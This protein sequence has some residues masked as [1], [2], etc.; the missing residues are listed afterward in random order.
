MIRVPVQFIQG[1]SVETSAH[2]LRRLPQG[3]WGVLVDG[4][5]F[6]IDAAGMVNLDGQ[7]F[8]PRDCPPALDL[9][10]EFL[11]MA[12]RTAILNCRMEASPAGY[13]ILHLDGS[14]DQ[15]SETVAALEARGSQIDCFGTAYR[16][17]DNG[18]QYQWFIRLKDS[19][20]DPWKV[21]SC[22]GH[23]ESGGPNIV[24]DPRIAELGA[25]LAR[26]GDALANAEAA[27]SEQETRHQQSLEAISVQAAMLRAAME[28]QRERADAES[29]ARHRLAN[30]VENLATQL[31]KSRDGVDNADTVR[32]LEQQLNEALA[33]WI[34]ADV[35]TK[36]AETA[37][38]QAEEQLEKLQEA[39][40]QAKTDRP[41]SAPKSRRNRQADLETS[42][43]M[44]LPSLVF[45]RDSLRFAA[46]QVFDLRALLIQLTRLNVNQI[47][48]LEGKKL[49]DA[50]KW[51][52]SHFSTGQGRDGR[53][54]YR[55]TGGNPV[56]TYQVL[57]S[58]KLAQSRDLEWLRRN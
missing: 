45:L 6:P 27:L 38:R 51:W 37:R 56:S 23:L 1:T 28:A 48:L 19:N 47:N 14:D 15:I 21:A 3:K 13:S 8:Y 54:Y 24:L 35:S 7:S 53:L 29:N 40:A 43:S 9:P 34:D 26:T 4:L 49:R 32:Q 16:A 12:E 20:I 44:L 31:A 10:E 55:Q 22:V 11:R 18:Q 36:A 52:E 33:G 57:L 50:N 17:A 2:Q 42:F 41:V 5:V 46:E 58:D 30:E 25:R 39:L